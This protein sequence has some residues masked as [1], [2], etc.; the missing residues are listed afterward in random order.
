MPALLPAFLTERWKPP[1]EWIL[2]IGEPN[3]PAA[4][5]FEMNKRNTLEA[6]ELMVV[7]S[8]ELCGEPWKRG[9][10]SPEK[11]SERRIR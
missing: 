11:V 10:L 4:Y 3:W 5:R 1:H 7:G 2:L 8:T 9:K 6:V